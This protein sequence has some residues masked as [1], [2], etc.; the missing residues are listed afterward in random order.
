VGQTKVSDLKL[1]GMLEELVDGLLDYKRLE[2]IR[3]FLCHISLTYVM[4]TPY[5]K[6]LHITLA[7][8]H[9]GQ[10]KFGWKMANREWAAYPFEPVENL[11][12]TKLQQCQEPPLNQVCLKPKMVIDHE[13]LPTLPKRIAPA[14]HLKS[15]I[16]TLCPQQNYPPKSFFVRPRCT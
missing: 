5:L 11:Q 15:D 2:Q 9:A 4:V 3:G 7:S 1:S 10:D 6:G 12:P 13:P 16:W 8:H 14:F